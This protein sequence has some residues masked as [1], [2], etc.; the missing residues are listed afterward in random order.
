MFDS[1][2][3][4]PKSNF[5]TGFQAN[6]NGFVHHRLHTIKDACHVEYITGV[7]RLTAIN[8]KIA[9]N[10]EPFVL[11]RLSDNTGDIDA[12]LWPERKAHDWQPPYANSLN[13]C[14]YVTGKVEYFKPRKGFANLYLPSN[15]LVRGTIVIDDIRRATQ[16]DIKNTKAL[17]TLPRLWCPNKAIFEKLIETAENIENT[18]LQRFVCR[19]LEQPLVAKKFLTAPA[20]TKYHHSYP[21]GLLEHSIEVACI[22][23]NIELYRSATEKELATVAALFH[24][25]GKIRSYDD[26]GY[27]SLNGRLTDHSAQT[28]EI[29][30]ESLAVLE[31]EEYRYAEALRHIWTCATPGARYGQPA[32]FAI[33]HAVQAADRLSAEFGNENVAFSN[34]NSCTQ[35][36]ARIGQLEYLRVV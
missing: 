21:G 20:S 22:V 28:L 34:A 2:N 35:K 27:M 36:S 32:K 12:I 31:Q 24:D 3:F 14:F 11:L 7:Y 29:C 10:N 33:A 9:R 23:N 6:T 13:E 30:A 25:L 4:Y 17:A 19:V 1:P 18:P 26:N 15:P 16:D 8:I 5:G